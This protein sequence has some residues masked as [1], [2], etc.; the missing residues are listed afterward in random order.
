LS[1]S[2]TEWS[3]TTELWGEMKAFYNNV[4]NNNRTKR[5]T[6]G[7]HVKRGKES[8]SI[9]GV[10]AAPTTRLPVSEAIIYH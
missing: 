2:D 6:P 7:S 5:S 9:A 3:E 8:A 10:S 1:V 4:R